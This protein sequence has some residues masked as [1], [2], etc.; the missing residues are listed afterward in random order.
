M[1][2]D[3]ELRRDEVFE[4]ALSVPPEE[5]HQLVVSECSGNFEL[6]A[7]V[8]R[9]LCLH[10]SMA[11]DFLEHPF[12]APNTS[13]PAFTLGRYEV[14]E[15]IGRG[16]MSCVYLAK[17]TVIGRQVAV[18]LV[19]TAGL[20]AA[21][22]HRRF[23]AEVRTLG[24][25]RH[26]NIVQVFDC[27]EFAGFPY[28]V[29][30]LLEGEDLALAIRNGRCGSPE[31]RIA[32]AAQLAGALHYIHEAGILHRDIKP[33]NVFLQRNGRVKLMDFGIARSLSP[34]T[35]QSQTFAGTLEYMSP[36]QLRGERANVAS[37]MYSYGLVL[38][39]LF[40]GRSLAAG[41]S[42]ADMVNGTLDRALPVDEL[43][44]V[45]TPEGIVRLIADAT[46]RIPQNR[47]ASFAVVIARL[48]LPHDAGNST[49]PLLE[50]RRR[51]STDDSR[52]E[53]VNDVNVPAPG[54]EIAPRKKSRWKYKITASVLGVIV[55]ASAAAFVRTRSFNAGVAEKRI[56][57]RPL[58]VG[59]GNET[60]P[61][62]SSDGTRV[63]YVWDDGDAPGSG[64]S[65]FVKQI[66]TDQNTRLTRSN[67]DFFPQW[68]PDN[69]LISFYR[70]PDI[71][72]IPAM[73]GRATKLGDARWGGIGPF[74]TWAGDSSGVV[75][76][77]KNLN[78]G[79][80]P[81]WFIPLDL[82]PRKQLTDPPVGSSDLTPAISPDGRT[83][84]FTRN[85]ASLANNIFLLPM[86]GHRPVGPLRQLTFDKSTTYF[87]LTWAQDNK[88][89]F[90]LRSRPDPAVLR[91]S[92][93]IQKP[94]ELVPQI[95]PSVTNFLAAA[96]RGDKLAWST[97]VYDLDLWRAELP[98]AKAQGGAHTRVAHTMREEHEPA[99]SPDGSMLVFV[100]NRNGGNELW[101]SD[102][103]GN[104]LTVLETRKASRPS[105][106]PDG[107]K[108]AY[109]LF[110]RDG[111]DI[112]VKPVQYGASKRITEE[113]LE[114]QYPVWSRNSQ[115]IYFSSDR[116]GK[117]DIW[118]VASKGGAAIRVTSNGGIRAA[119]SVDGRKL[120]FTK[121][122]SK[123]SI[124]EMP[125]EGGKETEVFGPLAS[126]AAFEVFKDG[127]FAAA[128]PLGGASLVFYSFESRQVRPI[129]KLGSF[130]TGHFSMSADRR[131]I[132]YDATR[133]QYGDLMMIE[134]LQNTGSE[135]MQGSR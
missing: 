13:I 81:L 21:D 104:N 60:M 128:G 24:S 113:R 54:S 46:A 98:K 50:D 48:R 52:A 8:E 131:H 87:Y 125:A 93:D 84:A 115:W 112:C 88:S 91:I 96:P 118:K 80:S 45:G 108:I 39:E 3:K 86:D 105:W 126:A 101:L 133:Y 62:F 129:E 83:L 25:V 130:F 14:Q 76:A 41:R 59:P 56:R 89:L 58:A 72:I 97:A 55:L 78:S 20:E 65:L 38:F 49:Q 67:T 17:D 102:A 42:V 19:M 73:G 77:D 23:L 40:C 53:R 4:A 107:T 12:V 74:Q 132:I 114:A 37:E 1:T 30:E 85:S 36:E 68:S 47:P 9:L 122:D 18:K 117:R 119:E 32:I 120:Y 121:E 94:K 109:E 66:D 82:S 92:L 5:R 124:W 29:M 61:S 26:D 6:Q 22:V 127:I 33:G 2:P 44:R 35:A 103:Y 100:S 111:V 123:L 79:T 15:V 16:G 99:L 31:D 69:R 75:T 134:G 70:H 64:K 43:R 135:E 7:E 71:M 106:S 90:C 116:A 57:I 11:T 51:E 110:D 63:V 10:D 27:G 28:L 34:A 95:L